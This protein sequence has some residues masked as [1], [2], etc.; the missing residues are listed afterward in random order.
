MYNLNTGLYKYTVK[1]LNDFEEYKKDFRKNVN[2][3]NRRMSK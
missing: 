3:Y 2:S 1:E